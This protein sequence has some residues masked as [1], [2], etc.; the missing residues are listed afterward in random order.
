MMLTHEDDAE[1]WDIVAAYVSREL[2]TEAEWREGALAMS[3]DAIRAALRV[4]D[5]D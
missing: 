4:S 3:L 5:D 2:K 1:E